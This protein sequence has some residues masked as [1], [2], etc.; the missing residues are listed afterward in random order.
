MK[1]R[2]E[3]DIDIYG[4]S[5]KKHDYEY[6]L[7]SSFLADFDGS[8][9]ETGKLKAKV[10]LDKSETMLLANFVIEGFVELTCDRSLEKFDYPIQLDKNLI[11]KY[12]E[13]FGELSDEILTIPKD[14]QKLNIA[15]Y[16]FEFIGLAIPMKKLHPKFVTEDE[17]EDAEGVLIYSTKKNTDS[18][19]KEDD[20][21]GEIDPR[22]NILNNLKKNDN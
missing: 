10:I 20:D 6:V 14:T 18:E 2:R 13:E 5:H 7:E 19:E 1:V 17:H 15:Q 21:S 9:V 4:L 8:L 22:W 16:I 3:F 11:F 12:G